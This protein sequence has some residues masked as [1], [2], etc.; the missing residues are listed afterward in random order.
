MES[1]KPKMRENKGITLIA[2]VVTI[3]ILLILAGVTLNL[4][5]GSDG[6]L[7]KATKAVTI[8]EIATN[9]EEIE[10]AV[11]EKRIEYYNNYEENKDKDL[12]SYLKE[13]L[14]NYKTPSGAI[15]TV[16][17]IGNIKYNDVIMATIDEKGKITLLDKD[18]IIPEENDPNKV[19]GAYYVYYRGQEYKEQA[20]EW[21]NNSKVAESSIGKL[22]KQGDCMLFEAEQAL[23]V[24]PAC[25]KAETMNISEYD[26]INIE[27][28][29]VE[30]KTSLPNRNISIVVLNNSGIVQENESIYFPNQG[31]IGR[32]SCRE[33]V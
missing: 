11:L 14:N 10:L 30:E 22:E 4:V 13:E 8:N 17:E 29:I 33:R 3:I 12:V 2:L 26:R 6:I 5:A 32:A 31:K 28:E 7:N 20:G 9:Q 24:N 1:E 23:S 21:E 18:N 25:T 27:M 19:K 16:D 15:L